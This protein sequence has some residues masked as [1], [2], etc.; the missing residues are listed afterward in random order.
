MWQ[1]ALYVWVSR[2]DRWLAHW[3]VNVQ[4]RV[5]LKSDEAPTFVQELWWWPLVPHIFQLIKDL[6]RCRLTLILIFNKWVRVSTSP[7]HKWLIEINLLFEISWIWRLELV[8]D[9]QLILVSIGLESADICLSLDSIGLEPSYICLSLDPISFETTYICLNLVGRLTCCRYHST[10][11]HLL[12][13]AKMGTTRTSLIQ[14]F[15]YYF[16]INWQLLILIHIG[17]IIRRLSDLLTEKIL[18]KQ[19]LGISIIL[20]ET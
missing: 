12:L 11:S 14:T 15:L 6:L 8:V 18:I 4:V 2:I 19:I 5:I 7:F 1:W 20:A 9:I 3:L 16:W 10:L 13:H 17:R